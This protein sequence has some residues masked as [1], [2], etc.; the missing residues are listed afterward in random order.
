MA[1]IPARFGQVVSTAG[2][3]TATQRDVVIS[4][5]GYDSGGL[6]NNGRVRLYGSASGLPDVADWY[7]SGDQMN[8]F[9]QA[10]GTAG[11]VN[12]DGFDGLPSACM[13][14]GKARGAW[15]YG[16]I[17]GLLSP[18]LSVKPTRS[19]RTA[20]SRRHGGRCQ[21]RRLRRCVRDL[22]GTTGS[23]GGSWLL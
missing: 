18:G 16:F 22:E 13:A 8:G 2:D 20:N 4:A 1:S 12:G 11:D 19:T 17:D 10:L 3:V 14:H 7:K 23:R 9:G 6:A 15:L 21:Q 5:P